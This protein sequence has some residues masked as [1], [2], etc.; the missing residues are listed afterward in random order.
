MGY[1]GLENYMASDEASDFVCT[2]LGSIEKDCEK[3]LK[4]KANEYN[5]P[6]YVNIALFAEA[7]LKNISI[8]SDD[9]LYKILEQVK[10]K[11]DEQVKA[12]KKMEYWKDQQMHITAF[13]RMSKNIKKILENA[14]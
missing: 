9:K 3:Q 10:N 7:F 8:Y 6:G 14:Y 11:L 13:K 4:N 2:V 12:I 5:T 1:M